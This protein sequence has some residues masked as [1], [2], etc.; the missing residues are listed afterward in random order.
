MAPLRGRS[1]RMARYL[2]GAAAL[3]GVSAVLYL[4]VLATPAGVILSGFAQVPLFIA[5]LTLGL[6]GAIAAS[7]AAALL[8][9][10]VLGLAGGVAYALVNSLPVLVLVQRALLSRRA[11]DGGVEWYTAGLLT[12]WLTGLGLLA[13][14]ALLVI[15]GAGEGGIGD[16]VLRQFEAMLPA[17]GPN[18]EALSQQFERVAP[19]L[20]GVAVT[21]WLALTAVNGAIGQAIASRSRRA[22]RPAPDIAETE[23]PNLLVVALAVAAALAF[24]TSGTLGVIAA[25][26][27]VVLS[28]AFLILGLAVIHAAAKGLRGRRLLLTAVYTMIALVG[29]PGLA[30]IGLGL[31]EQG[32]GLKRRFAAPR[33]GGA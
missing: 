18:E 17:F 16:A 10:M 5:G 2:I 8:S 31:I 27:T 23:L 24:W 22:L 21:S 9:M 20:P 15:F 32:F 12:T 14:A 3:G 13:L 28:L 19:I 26:V 33:P 29:L 11:A 6:T 30:I 1:A 4:S 25:N 7:A